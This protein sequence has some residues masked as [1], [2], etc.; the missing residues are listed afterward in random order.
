[1]AHEVRRVGVK[2][3]ID[4]QLVESLGFPREKYTGIERERRWL[5][6]GPPQG[7]VIQTLDVADTYITGT[8]M[9]L[10]D[11]RPVDGSSFLYRYR[12]TKKGDVDSKTRLLTTIYLAEAEFVVLASVLK[13]PSITK[14]RYRL[15]APRGISLSYDVF[16]GDLAGLITAEVEFDSD[17]LMEN[18]PVPNFAVREIT[19]DLRY[20]GGHLVTNGLPKD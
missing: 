11:A 2:V 15:R 19:E 16:Q 6:A 13:G 8:R 10:R 3:E 20:S 17:E 9:R 1:M 4:Q 5:C 14:R 7:T 18:F 12:L